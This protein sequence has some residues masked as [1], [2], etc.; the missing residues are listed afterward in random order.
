MEKTRVAKANAKNRAAAPANLTVRA[1]LALEFW[2]LVAGALAFYA[3]GSATAAA[4]RAV[5]T[6]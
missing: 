1:L 4:A 5:I 6:L 3:V 2:A